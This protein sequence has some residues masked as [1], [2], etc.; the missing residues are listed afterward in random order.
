MSEM[1]SCDRCKKIVDVVRTIS[2]WSS[3][4]SFYRLPFLRT[5]KQLCI[6]CYSE[7]KN[8]IN[9]DLY[10]LQLP[11]KYMVNEND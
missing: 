8:W 1:Y 2:Y 5:N 4:V 11:M 7:F 6:I 9:N 10:V 3:V